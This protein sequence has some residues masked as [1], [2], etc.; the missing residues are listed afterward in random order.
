[1]GTKRILFHKEFSSLDRKLD[2]YLI[3]SAST[4]LCFQY[5]IISLQTIPETK[6]Q[7]A[8]APVQTGITPNHHI[9]HNYY[10]KLI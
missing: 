4:F 7:D 5:I 10:T 1:M 2:F 8:Q 9:V 3:T 6:E